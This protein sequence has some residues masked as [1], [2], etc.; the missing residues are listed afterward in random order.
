[1]AMTSVKKHLIPAFCLVG[2]LVCGTGRTN[3][4][5][6]I[7]QFWQRTGRRVNTHPFR[8]DQIIQPGIG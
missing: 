5:A 6:G 7:S 8:L 4:G 2:S 1:M 3:G